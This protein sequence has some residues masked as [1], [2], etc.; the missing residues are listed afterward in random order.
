M[1]LSG[2]EGEKYWY[3]LR[4]GWNGSGAVEV[5]RGG[6][7][8]YS[9]SIEKAFEGRQTSRGV[10]ESTAPIEWNDS[11]SGSK[12][13]HIWLPLFLWPKLALFCLKTC[14]CETPPSLQCKKAGSQ[15]QSTV[16]YLEFIS[17]YCP[18]QTKPFHQGFFNTLYFSFILLWNKLGNN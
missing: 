3:I 16:F 10:E 15:N 2:T 4:M 14:V 5:R 9:W 11:V 17:G 13:T 12:E 6:G 7:D 1:A 18:Y 8:L